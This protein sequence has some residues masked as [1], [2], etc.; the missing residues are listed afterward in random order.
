MGVR[1]KR[2]GPRIADGDISAFEQRFGIRL[3]ED[4]RE[5]LQ[6][7]SGGVPVSN[8]FDIPQLDGASSI[9][10]FLSITEIEANKEEVGD[11]FLSNSWPIAYAE[12]GNYLCLVLGEKAGVYFWDHELEAEEGQLPSWNN[13]FRVADNFAS[14]WSSLRPFDISNVELKPGQVQSIWVDPDF[15]PECD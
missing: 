15:K 14:F 1:I 3:P 7:N 8:E 5:F 11:R 2:K 4:Y 12:G 10:E 6:K 9:N 13:M